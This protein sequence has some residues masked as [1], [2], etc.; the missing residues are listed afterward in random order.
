[1][2]DT[3]KG[4]TCP[5]CLEKKLSLT[6]DEMDIPY[7]G[8]TFVFSMHCEGCAF[9]KADIEAAEMKDPCRLTFTIEKEEDMKI[10]VVKSSEGSIKVP[11][12][13]M[14]VTPGSASEGYISNIEGLLNRFEKV[15][16]DEKENSEEDS[17]KT[18]A[19]NLLKKIRKVKWGEMPLKIV[20]ED[21]SGN[22]AIISE[23]TIIEKLKAK[24]KGS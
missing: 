24:K 17:A 12:L 8:K 1:M 15:I 18:T 10:R 21:P 11:Q 2:A 4:E 14:S 22:S 20:I 9:H 13:H 5:I 3:L 7:F 16:E 23:R 19:K 6:E